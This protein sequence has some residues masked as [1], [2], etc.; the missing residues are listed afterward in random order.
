[1]YGISMAFLTQIC[2]W[3]WAIRVYCCPSIKYLK[4]A[5]SIG[6]RNGHQQTQDRSPKQGIAQRKRDQ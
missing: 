4:C 1:M 6:R 5:R 2:L 3:I